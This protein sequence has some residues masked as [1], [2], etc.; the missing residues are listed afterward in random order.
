MLS[1]NNM[2]YAISSSQSLLSRDKNSRMLVQ[3]LKSCD[4]RT[5]AIGDGGNDVNMIQQ[6][7]IGVGISGREGLLAGRQPGHLIIVL[8]LIV[9]AGMVPILAIKY[10]RYA[11]AP[12]KINILQQA[13]R[14]GGPILSLGNF[15]RQQRLILKD[16]APVSITQSQNINPVYEL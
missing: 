7:D 11:Y 3:I 9:A 5:L 2:H 15:E 13:E 12:S 6:A 4:Y 1:V 10:F 8:E 16:F 14:L